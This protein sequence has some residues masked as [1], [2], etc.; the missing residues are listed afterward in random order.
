MK[1]STQCNLYNDVKSHLMWTKI[2]FK[3]RLGHAQLKLPSCHWGMLY[4]FVITLYKLEKAMSEIVYFLISFPFVML[5]EE[6]A[7]S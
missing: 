5:H 1:Y 6:K 7:V 3:A 4:F 2:Q